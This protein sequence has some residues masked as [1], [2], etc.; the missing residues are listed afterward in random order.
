[1]LL[2]TLKESEEL[3]TLMDS[4]ILAWRRGDVTYLEETLLADMQRY[5]ELNKVLV[6]DRNH[7]WLEQIRDLLTHDNDYLVVVGALHLVGDSG[8]PRLLRSEGINV[9]QFNAVDE[10]QAR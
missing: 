7:R 1:M 8:V 5:E 4:I 9:Q 6:V 2:Q 10:E 3:Q